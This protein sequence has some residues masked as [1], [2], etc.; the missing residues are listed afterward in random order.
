MWIVTHRLKSPGEFMDRY[1]PDGPAGGLFLPQKFG[2][3]EGHAVCLEL[4]LSWLGEVHFVQGTVEQANMIFENCGEKRSGAV[5]RFQPEEAEHRDALVAQVKGSTGGLNV[6][7]DDRVSCDLDAHFF[8]ADDTPM[9]ARAVDLSPTGVRLITPKPLSVGTS[10]H[11]RLEHRG[12]KAMIHL[13]GR[14]ARL[15]FSGTQAAMGIEFELASRGER[16]RA[17]RFFDHL[18]AAFNVAEQQETVVRPAVVQTRGSDRAPVAMGVRFS[19]AQTPERGGQAVDL[20]I[21]GMFIQS[22]QLLPVGS[23]LKVLLESA[24]PGRF[25]QI[26]GKVIRWASKGDRAGGMAVQFT[27]ITRQERKVIRQAWARLAPA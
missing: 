25:S 2:M 8:G 7:G 12:F 20:S 13:R 6:R 5:V 1:L 4:H 3:R 9:S 17:A 22:D 11:V 16:Q 23:E 15:D 14:V 19:T 27:P 24:Q 21:T 10:V 18:E 26:T